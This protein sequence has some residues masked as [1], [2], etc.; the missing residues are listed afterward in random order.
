MKADPLVSVVIPTFR[1]P[2]MVVRAVHSVLHQ[3]IR[4][5][6]ILVV[7]DG[8]DDQSLAALKSISSPQLRLL[9]LPKQV[10]GSHA[11]NEGVLASRGEWVAFLDDDDLWF[12][13]KLEKQLEVARASKAPEPIVSC[14]VVAHTASGDFLWP[15]KVPSEPLSEYLLARNSWSQGENLLQ[16][17]TPLREQ[18]ITAEGWLRG[19]SP[20]ASRLGLAAP[21]CPSTGGQDRISRRA[22]GDLEPGAISKQREPQV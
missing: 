5:L 4:D 7:I 22:I 16:T 11:R 2:D 3:S 6:E 15:R 10:G 21:C 8:N 14:Q 13:K 1:R 9:Q 19:R 17:S 12:P 18:A 20:K